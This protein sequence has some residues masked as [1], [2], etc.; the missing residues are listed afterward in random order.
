MSGKAFGWVV[1]LLVVACVIV[2]AGIGNG[3]FGA[4][5]KPQ[6]VGGAT[7]NVA[8]V[9]PADPN[10]SPGPGY[11]KVGGIWRPKIDVEKK[12]TEEAASAYAS[13]PSAGST[14]LVSFDSNKSTQLIKEALDSKDESLVSRLSVMTEAK[15]FDREA[16]EKD[17]QAYLDEI[18]PGRIWQSAPEAEGVKPIVHLGEFYRQLLQGESAPLSVKIEPNLP[19]TFY[20]PQL[21]RFE[22]LLTSITVRSDEKGIANATYTATPGSRGDVT[23]LAASPVNSGQARFLINVVLPDDSV[24]A[25]TGSK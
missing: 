20:S 22:N 5:N 24:T 15:P 6:M 7:E 17:P 9:T 3:W 12:A 21:G 10:I 23:I 4:G 2:V 18:E 13:L 16:F 8:A 19:V 25:S 11:V 14:P 1:G